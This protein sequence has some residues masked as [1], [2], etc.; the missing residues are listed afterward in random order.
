M[1]VALS[2]G[3]RDS[4]EVWLEGY[5]V[6]IVTAEK[7]DSI[8]RHGI[9]WIKDVGLVVVDEIHLLNDVSRGPTLEVTITRLRDLAKFQILALSATISNSAELA[10]WLNA[11]LVKSITDLWNSRAG[12][13]MT[14]K[15]ISRVIRSR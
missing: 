8:I 7:L 13:I 14:Q 9:D 10:G 15:Y 3:G 2:M 1:K 6:V 4:K 12:C 11:E 5:D